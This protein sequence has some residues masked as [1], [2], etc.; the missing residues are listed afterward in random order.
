MDGKGFACDHRW[1]PDRG[2]R[3]RRHIAGGLDFALDGEVSAAAA[4][5]SPAVAEL[6]ADCLA[7]SETLFQ[8]YPHEQ[9]VRQP[10]AAAR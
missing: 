10:A 3:G 6:S 2:D 4:L 5:A 1:C 9:Q 7:F 8:D